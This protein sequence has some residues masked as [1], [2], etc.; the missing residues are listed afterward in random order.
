M[1]RILIGLFLLVV[2]E[3]R[4]D[5]VARYAFDGNA[6][7]TVGFVDGVVGEDVLFGDGVEG[8][9][10][11]FGTD[12]GSAFGTINVVGAFDPGNEDFSIAFWVKRGD[13]DSGDA[14]GVFDALRSTGT[15]YQCNFRNVPDANQMAFRLDDDRGQFALLIDPE[16]TDD[17]EWHHF[18]LV[19]NRVAGGA[20]I[21]RDGGVAGVYDIVQLSGAISPDGDLWIGGLNNSPVLG[22]DGSLDELRFYDH[23]LA[24]EEVE[25]LAGG[26]EA[27]L[28]ITGIE[29]DPVLLEWA[30]TWNAEEGVSYG[31]EVSADLVSWESKATG[32]VGG[33]WV[34]DELVGSGVRYY[35][36]VREP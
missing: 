30:I 29:K 10:A 16:P 32:I 11:V 33:R 21:Y 31:V 17:S 26:E 6:E 14:D 1:V 36:V 20:L 24:A 13:G 4:G 9:A 19:V 35:R 25:A 15:G 3:A 12:G 2:V 8:G 18:A 23:A 28:V 27:E 22:L 7:D 34:D 5:L